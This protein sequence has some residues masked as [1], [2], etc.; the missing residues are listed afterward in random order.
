VGAG[1]AG[2]NAAKTISKRPVE[3]TIIDRENYHLF[4]PLLYQVASASLSPGEIAQPI[5]HIVGRR[6]NVR[7]IRA[8]VAALELDRSRLVL[9]DGS[10]V[11]YDYLVVASGTRHSYFS[12]PSWEAFAPGLKS[13]DDALEIR[14]RILTAFEEAEQTADPAVRDALLTFVVVGGGP[15]GVELA[16][17]IAEIARHTLAREFRSIDTRRARVV[18]YEGGSRL[19]PTFPA[20][21]SKRAEQALRGLGVE[22]RMDTR[23]TTATRAGVELEDQSLASRTILWAAGVEAS[24]I[25]RTL[26]VKVDRVGRVPVEGDLSVPGHPEVFVIGDL[27]R[28]EGRDGQPLPGIA[29]VAIQQGRATGD[30]IWRAITGEATRPFR[31]RNRGVIATIGRAAAVAQIGPLHLSGFP[32]WVIWLAV[33]IVYLIGFHNRLAV[34]LSWSWSYLTWQRG[35]R[36]ITQSVRPTRAPMGMTVENADGATWDRADRALPRTR[37]AAGSAGAAASRPWPAA[38]IDGIG[39]PDRIRPRGCHP[40]L[41]TDRTSQ[42]RPHGCDG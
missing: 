33:H 38:E 10:G 34:L 31:Y 1:F 35:A 28:A 40:Y 18:L 7:V 30:N 22:V 9:A 29:P 32:A 6:P 2:L 4:Q 20:D 3:V 8:E 17:A 25:G 23:V 27:A 21:L 5:R 42:H 19:L 36:L 12:H 16:G 37:S 13:L 15:T 24:P 39:A 41:D 14:R 11:P 26:G